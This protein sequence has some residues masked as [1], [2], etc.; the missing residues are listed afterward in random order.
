[1]TDVV[2]RL[3]SASHGH[4]DTE[5]PNLCPGSVRPREGAGVQNPRRLAQ[6]QGHFPDRWRRSIQPSA[7]AIRHAQ[8]SRDAINALVDPHART[9][10]AAAVEA[11]TFVPN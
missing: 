2:L 3:P 9:I 6:P 10:R 8:M 1:M 7:M 11:R 4:L 5:K